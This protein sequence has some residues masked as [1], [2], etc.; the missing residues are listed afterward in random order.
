M[1]AVRAAGCATITPS[2]NP[3]PSRRQRMFPMT[4]AKKPAPLTAAAPDFQAQL[5]PL[6][7]RAAQQG[8]EIIITQHGYPVAR[9]TPYA[10]QPGDPPF[11]AV[12][13]PAGAPADLDP[14]E[15]PPILESFI[16][17]KRYTLQVFGD[18]EGPMPAEWFGEVSADRTPTPDLPPAAAPDDRDPEGEEEPPI[19]E[20]VFEI[21]D[22]D[23][24]VVERKVFHFQILGD[25]MAPIDEEWE[26]EVNP[27]RVLNPYLPRT[28]AP[29]APDP[30]QEPL[31]LEDVFEIKDADGKVVER[32]VFHFKILGGII[33]PTDESWKAEVNPDR[34]PDPELPPVAAPAD[35]DPDKEPPI[36]ESFINGKRFTLQILG[37][38]VGPM[39]AEWFGSPD[40]EEEV[41]R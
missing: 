41:S 11:P 39:P 24:N 29:A 9:V 21:K 18:I 30:E 27:D 22:A 6:L 20:D 3:I 4:A 26:A 33:A 31:V 34:L 36:L 16:N 25:I 10:P 37:D 13:K 28:A 32:K 1:T 40:A 38:I 5:E 35:P 12:E 19:L 17:G 7:N 23:G 2:V 14:E 15:E 8:Q